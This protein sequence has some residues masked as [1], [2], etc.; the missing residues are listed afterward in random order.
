MSSDENHKFTLPLYPFPDEDVPIL[1]QYAF[2]EIIPKI[3]FFQDK[4]ILSIEVSLSAVQ[5]YWY[6]VDWENLMFSGIR[7]D[8]LQ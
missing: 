8:F 3:V 5:F 7:R 6:F 1:N 2:R 4:R